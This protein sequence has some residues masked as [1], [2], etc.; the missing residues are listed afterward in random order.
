MKKVLFVNACVR[1][2]SR[3]LVLARQVLGQLGGK[4]EEVDLGRERLRPLDWE[5][6]Q[7]RDRLAAENLDIFGA[8]VE[9]ILQ[10]ALGEI[11]AAGL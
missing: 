2:Q 9:G 5:Q 11:A 1:P 6:L 3:T 10:K 4:V 7:E 8:D